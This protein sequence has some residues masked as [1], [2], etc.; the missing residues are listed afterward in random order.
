MS[1]LTRDLLKPYRVQLLGGLACLAVVALSGGIYAYL[2]GPTLQVVLTGGERGGGY[3]TALIPWASCSDVP[4]GISALILTAALLV[5]VALVKGLAHLGQSY[6][7]NGAAETVGFQ[8]R[9]KLYDHLMQWPLSTRRQHT[10]GDLMTRLL[11]D[12]QRVQEAAVAAP[13]SLVREILGALV[14]LV[15]AIWM[16]PRLALAAGIALPLAGVVIALLSRGVKRASAGR[17]TQ[18]GALADRAAQGLGGFREVKSCG[19]EGREVSRFAVHGHS[20]LRWAKRRILT[21]AAAPL[22]NEVAA[23]VA[24]GGTL[25]YAGGQIARGLL[26]AERFISFF[27]AVLMMYRPIKEIGRAIH[28]AAA[29]QAS[30]ERVTALLQQPVEDLEAEADERG[31]R[32]PPLRRMLALENIGFSYADERPTLEGIDLE[33][34]VGSIVA[35]AGRS[36]AG[37]TTLANLVC[38]LERPA[39]GRLLWDGQDLS[40]FPLREIRTRVALVPQQP[41]LFSGTVA[42]NLRYGAPDASDEEMA[43]ALTSAGLAET[44]NALEEG[45]ETSIGP[46]GVGLSVGEIQRLALARALLREATVLV[47]DE[48]SSALDARSASILIQTLETLRSRRAILLIAHSEALLEIADRVVE[49]RDGRVVAGRR[50]RARP[51]DCRATATRL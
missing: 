10:L 21:R 4:T 27:A 28:L 48:P 34:G 42:D 31:P 2:T 12:V 46:G 23:S 11:D 18:I 32:L 22:F 43:R 6:L 15:V 51:T 49:V 9:V 1:S 26:P 16:S 39:R 40:E 37:K 30:V 20:A 13:I 14:L 5:G 47:L 44:V 25:I 19:S 8:L 3:L 7:L 17:Q 24:L 50:Q 41:L 35:L 29:G 33:L 38:G 45:F 36:G